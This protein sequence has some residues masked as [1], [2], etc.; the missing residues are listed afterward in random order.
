M[1]H[2]SARVTPVHVLLYDRR[3]GRGTHRASAAKRRFQCTHHRESPRC[4]N[5]RANVRGGVAEL[6]GQPVR[7]RKGLI[8]RGRVMDATGTCYPGVP[9]AVRSALPNPSTIEDSIARTWT[10]SDG[11]F[12]VRGVPSSFGMIQVGPLS[13]GLAGLLAPALVEVSRHG[14][15]RVVELGDVIVR[16][17]NVTT[18]KGAV[19]TAD[20]AGTTGAIVYVMAP[21]AHGRPVE[22]AYSGAT[23]VFELLV[24]ATG[25][26]TIV[27]MWRDDH[28]REFV[29]SVDR[30]APGESGVVI[31]LERQPGEANDSEH[32]L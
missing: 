19:V 12:E 28:E 14:H 8:A 31:R 21:D 18:V 11:S 5:L 23:G 32:C 30:V 6:I 2:E 26:L 24:P 9:I 17:D 1:R 10:W 15:G 22:C 7:L 16:V 29:G 4:V 3:A 27:A 25:S 13:Y 20:G